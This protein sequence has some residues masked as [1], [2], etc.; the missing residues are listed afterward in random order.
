MREFHITTRNQWF[1]RLVN[2]RDSRRRRHRDRQMFVEGVQMISALD[3][4]W[5]V[6]ALAYPAERRLSDWAMQ[7]L[8]QFGDATR[9]R[10]APSLFREASTKVAAPD[11]VNGP[12]TATKDDTA[13]IG[14]ELIAIVESP[15]ID[16]TSHSLADSGVIVL[17]D[18]PSSHGNLGTI[19]R[20]ADGFGTSAV[21]ILGHGVDPFD[22]RTIRASAGSLFRVPLA[23]FEGN[24]AFDAWLGASGAQL[25]GTT[26]AAPGQLGQ[27]HLWEPLV[28]AFGNEKSGLSTWLKTRCD[29]LVGLEMAGYASSLNVANMVAICLYEVQRQERAAAQ[30]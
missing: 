26:A 16:A 23:R 20:A 27:V 29:Q 15:D 9:L 8:E 24:E 12:L 7:R 11:E 13:A 19:I 2:L 4:R 25:V 17:M 1:Q 30:G 5:K 3:A 6:V 10:I 14:S 22:P 21:A 28:L 18:R